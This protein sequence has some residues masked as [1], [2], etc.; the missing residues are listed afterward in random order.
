MLKSGN[1]NKQ[2]QNSL[3][4]F[5]LVL[6]DRLSHIHYEM[7]ML[8]FPQVVTFDCKQYLQQLMIS[9]YLMGVYHEGGGVA[10]SGRTLIFDDSQD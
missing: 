9:E 7:H 10:A 3:S 4:G 2:K 5:K 8:M 6:R 1:K